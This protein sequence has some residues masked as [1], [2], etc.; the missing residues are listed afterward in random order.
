[1]SGANNRDSGWGR[2]THG[3]PLAV[4]VV[5]ALYIII[6]LLPI[7]EL[8]ALAALVALILRTNLQWLKK[9]VK[10]PWIAASDTYWGGCR[11]FLIPWFRGSS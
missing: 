3:A 1:M 2:L 10:V 11:L 8:V 9:F 4:F 7:L 5:A 6:R